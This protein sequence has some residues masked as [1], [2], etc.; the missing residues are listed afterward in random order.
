MI[1]FQSKS[2]PDTKEKKNLSEQKKKRIKASLPILKFSLKQHK[3]HLPWI[4]KAT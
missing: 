3:P 2:F 1:T 4:S